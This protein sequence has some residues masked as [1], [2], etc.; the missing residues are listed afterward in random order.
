MVNE[1]CDVINTNF[2]QYNIIVRVVVW[3]GVED[4]DYTH[5]FVVVALFPNPFPA[6][7]LLHD[8]YCCTGVPYTSHLLLYPLHWLLVLGLSS[9]FHHCFLYN[10]LLSPTL[11]SNIFEKWLQDYVRLGN[12]WLYALDV[13][14]SIHVTLTQ[15]CLTRPPD[16]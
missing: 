12:P 16:S 7:F 3:A 6:F 1:C 13:R 15:Q 10:L 14:S 8:G 5:V 9:H 4:R 11:V 2:S